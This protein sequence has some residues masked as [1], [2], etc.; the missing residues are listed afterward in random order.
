MVG[1]RKEER[2]GGRKEK[3]REFLVPWLKWGQREGAAVSSFLPPP[4]RGS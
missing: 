3:K 1:G 4:A 2:K